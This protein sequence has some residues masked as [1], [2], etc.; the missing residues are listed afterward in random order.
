MQENRRLIRETISRARCSVHL[1]IIHS[2]LLHNNV[3]QVELAHDLWN[4]GWSMIWPF[5]Q[6]GYLNNL[7]KLAHLLG[8]GCK[9]QRWQ[10]C[11][12]PSS[13]GFDSWHSQ[14]FISMQW[15]LI[16]VTGQRKVDRGLKCSSNPSSASQCQAIITKNKCI[17]A[18]CNLRCKKLQMIIDLVFLPYVV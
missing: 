1:F 11:F 8:R 6:F 14:T 15:R 17:W 3:G 12:S 9:A 10:S 18:F 5:S 7:I 13:L 4:V 16:D 2:R